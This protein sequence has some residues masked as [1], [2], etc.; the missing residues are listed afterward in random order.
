MNR[1]F[2]AGLGM[3]DALWSNAVVPNSATRLARWLK[4]GVALL[5]ACRAS[6]SQAGTEMTLRFVMLWYP[7]M[8]LGCPAAQRAGAAEEIAPQATAIAARAS[9]L[10]S[11]APH[12]E[13]IMERMEDG[14]E[15]P[16]DDFGLRLDDPEGSS[17]ES[18]D[19]KSVV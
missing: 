19:R 7:N 6:A 14:A 11:F 12:N 8:D 3:V 2:E 10:A 9:Y 5:G 18:R 4:A 17:A 13:Y 16:P 15:V 1:L